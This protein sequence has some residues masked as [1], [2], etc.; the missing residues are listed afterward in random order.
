[1]ARDRSLPSFQG[2]SGE[3]TF[4]QR[5]ATHSYTTLRHAVGACSRQVCRLE[6]S[7]SQNCKCYKIDSKEQDGCPMAQAVS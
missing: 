3:S 7:K 2:R 4:Y 1:M 6:N 5:L